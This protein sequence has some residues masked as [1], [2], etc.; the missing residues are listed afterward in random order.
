MGLDPAT[1]GGWEP[2]PSLHQEISHLPEKYRTPIV[3]C[4]LEGLTH[5][6][7]ARRLG[8]PLGTVK[9]RLARA[10]DLLR[11]RL[12]HRGVTLSAAALVSQLSIPSAQAAVPASLEFATLKAAQALAGTAGASLATTSAVSIPVAALVEGVLQTMF[13]NQVK[14]LALPLLLIAGTVATGVVVAAQGGGQRD[15]GL[16]GQPSRA[17]RRGNRRGWRRGCAAISSGF[18]GCVGDDLSTFRPADQRRAPLS[19]SSSPACIIRR[20]RTSIDSAGGRM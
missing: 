3:L 7:A 9:G 12:T 16:S 5:D 11:R 2:S 1:S 13:L 17:P 15:A 6:E 8:W 10:K 14:M 4:Y 19:T 18:Q 20:L